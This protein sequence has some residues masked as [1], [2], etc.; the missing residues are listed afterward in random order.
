MFQYQII[1]K[2]PKHGY[3]LCTVSVIASIFICM[4][5]CSFAK[6][7]TFDSKGEN[8]IE[9]FTVYAKLKIESFGFTATNRV[10]SSEGQVVFCFS[11]NSWLIEFTQTGG[12]FANTNMEFTP[13]GTV[14][15]CK[16]I[17][18]GV[19]SYVKFPERF[20]KKT[21]GGSEVFDTATAIPLFF[22]PLEQLELFVPW[23]SYCPS[24]E[25][26]LVSSNHIRRLLTTAMLDR[27]DNV[28]TYSLKYVEP[29]N[30]F[31]SELIITNDGYLVKSDGSKFLASPPFEKGFVEF[32]FKVIAET[33]FSGIQFPLHT[34]LRQFMPKPAA[35]NSNEIYPFSIS[36][37]HVE[38][39][40]RGYRHSTNLPAKLVALDTRHKGLRD[41]VTVNYFVTNDQWTA[42]S[43]PSQQNLRSFFR[44]QR[45][46]NEPISNRNK[47][48]QQIFCKLIF[49][50]RRRGGISSSC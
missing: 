29:G 22:P 24:P 6:A 33:N 32:S 31:L 18:D 46:K 43:E 28:G 13:I 44:Q 5:G 11:S 10:F 26:P 41:T 4:I 36:E 3:R 1:R 48:K 23:L 30:Y 39:I 27:Q 37:L 42:I 47:A 38:R 20:A 40:T 15:S 21:A 16:S 34:V 49:H 17:P 7:Q 50:L 19:R 35:K 2:N 12:G 25:L 8:K 9:P 14:F 45:I